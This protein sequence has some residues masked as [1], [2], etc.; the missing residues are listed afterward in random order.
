MSSDAKAPIIIKR[1][2][3]IEAGHHGGAW[4]VAIQPSPS[5]MVFH[6][7]SRSPFGRKESF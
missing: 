6:R 3:V 1:K 2:K 5:V 4:K 7:F